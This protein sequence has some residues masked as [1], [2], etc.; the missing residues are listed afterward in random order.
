MSRAMGLSR[1]DATGRATSRSWRIRRPVRS[2]WRRSSLWT[3][4]ELWKTHRARFPQLLG[5]RTERAAHN[6]PQAFF[7]LVL[8]TE[9]QERLQ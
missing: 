6:G 7:F 1:G 2:C 5:R 3:V 4:P 8:K 9:K